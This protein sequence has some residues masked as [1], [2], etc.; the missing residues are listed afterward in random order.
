M[1]NEKYYIFDLDGT[2]A[3]IEHR[4]HLV[5]GKKKNWSLFYKGCVND[6]PNAAVVDLYKQLDSSDDNI[7]IIF[8]GR[9]NIVRRETQQW[10][11][12]N[13]IFYSLLMMR[14]EGD[15][16]PDE[17]LKQEWLNR[18]LSHHEMTLSQVSAVFD[19]RQKVVNMWRDIG[20]T[21]FQ[22]APGDF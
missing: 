6:S 8:S 20:L 15:Y 13:E 21:C 22:V 3:D 1:S 9:S 12:D 11:E 10:L 14:P 16:T 17:V 7:M 18:Y 2:L 19:D 5:S 4:R